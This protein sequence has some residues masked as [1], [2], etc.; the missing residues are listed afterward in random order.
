MPR[1]WSIRKVFVTLLEDRTQTRRSS[2]LNRSK[3]SVMYQT[4]DALKGNLLSVLVFCKR[5]KSTRT[6]YCPTFMHEDG[7][8]VVRK[9]I[10][11]GSGSGSGST[12]SSTLFGLRH[13]TVEERNHLAQRI[14]KEES[15]SHLA[16]RCSLSTYTFRRREHV[17]GTPWLF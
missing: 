13:A 5:C 7:K 1:S 10:C 3:Y 15:P 16:S 12:D 2:N 11:Y 14:W 17:R 4:A 6:G 9:I 8:Y